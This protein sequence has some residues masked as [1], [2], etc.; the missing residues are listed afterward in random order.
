MTA[1]HARILIVGGGFSGLGVAYRLR[2]AG[3]EDLVILERAAEV[4]GVWQ[5]NTYPGCTC[6]VPSHLYSF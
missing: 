5:A 4:G 2:Q 3:I 6:D 1:Q